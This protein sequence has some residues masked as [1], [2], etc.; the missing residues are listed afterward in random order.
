MKPNIPPTPPPMKFNDIPLTS[1]NS[2]FNQPESPV[3]IYSSG[4]FPLEQIFSFF[5]SNY[6]IASVSF[7][8]RSVALSQ[9]LKLAFISPTF[10]KN[11]HNFF[12]HSSFLPALLRKAYNLLNISIFHHS[13]YSRY[14]RI[15][16]YHRTVILLK[17]L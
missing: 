7:S 1:V 6:F 14:C 9:S 11:F 17:S 15:S 8:H 4:R 10:R 2:I 13:F 16:L 3:K 5:S 12:Y